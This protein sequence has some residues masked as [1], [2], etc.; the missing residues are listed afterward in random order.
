MQSAK[1]HL[2]PVRPPSLPPGGYRFAN[3]APFRW[4]APLFNDHFLRT[5]RDAP[6]DFILESID[7]RPLPETI[8]LLLSLDERGDLWKDIPFQRDSDRR[9][10]L[11]LPLPRCGLFY[12][13]VK[14]SPDAGRTW[15]VEPRP[16]HILFVDPPALK[17]LKL[18]TLLPR[19]SGTYSDWSHRLEAIREMGFNAVHLL[20]ITRMGRSLSPYSARDLFEPDPLFCDPAQPGSASEQWAAFVETAARLGIRLCIDLVLNHIARD[21]RVAELRP[22]WIL[23]DP[24]EPDGFKRAGC[25]HQN[26]WIRWEDLV[27]LN[28]DHPDPAVREELENYMTQ[29]A[30]YWSHFAAQTGGLIRFDNYHSRPERFLVQL[31]RSLRQHYPDLLMFAEYF[32]DAEALEQSVTNGGINLLLAT[33]WEY[34]FVPDLRRYLSTLHSRSPRLRYL[35]PIT[36]HDTGTPAHLF[37]SADST[38]PRYAVNALL[39]TGQTGLVQGVEWGQVEKIHFIGPPHPL[40]ENPSADYRAFIRRIH[41]IL[42]EHP[43]FHQLGNLVFVDDGHPAVLAALRQSPQ[44]IE[45]GFLIVANFDI[46]RAHTVRLK[47]P[48]DP[49]PAP[50]VVTD[51]LHPA[52]RRIDISEPFEIRLEPCGAGVYHLHYEDPSHALSTI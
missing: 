13:R 48:D 8:T 15:F 25:W 9:C 30:L 24:T 22:D 52:L 17:S 21:S 1:S 34:P 32:A 6:L 46:T 3:P 11:H 33:T 44:G 31:T 41:Q 50:L 16:H 38:R 20:P 14:Y 40:S 4:V 5:I 36:T 27:L 35:T 39:G 37:G 10:H 12:C 2:N 18:Y 26:S 42:D 28:Y 49:R 43:A 29:Y 51:L 45:G 7:E 19:V 47:L 23:T